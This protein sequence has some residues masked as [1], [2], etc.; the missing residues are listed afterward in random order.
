MKKSVFIIAEAGVNHNGKIGCGFK[1]VDVMEQKYLTTV[2]GG[3]LGTHII[4]QWLKIP[5]CGVLNNGNNSK[6]IL[7]VMY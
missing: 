7:S 5:C 1:L 3:N 2:M 6:I 4:E